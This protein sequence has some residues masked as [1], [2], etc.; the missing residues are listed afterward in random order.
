MDRHLCRRAL[1]QSGRD[2]C[3]DRRPGSRRCYHGDPSSNAGGLYSRL[4]IRMAV[5]GRRLPAPGLALFRLTARSLIADGFAAEALAPAPNVADGWRGEG[6]RA[7]Q[8]ISVA[9]AFEEGTARG[10]S[11]LLV[12]V[13][14]HYEVG[15]AC[16]DRRVD[17]V[18]GKHRL[19]AAAP[20]A[21]SKVIGCVAGSRGQPDMVVDG[22]VA[23]D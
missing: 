23:G 22:I 14:P 17:Q 10:R 20:G 5:L 12:V 6:H 3:R 16:L 2:R 9:V 4:P 21:D 8:R 19:V 7:A 15:I 13:D 1:W 18:A 11:L